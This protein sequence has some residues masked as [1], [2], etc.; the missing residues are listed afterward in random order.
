M[1]QADQCDKLCPGSEEVRFSLHHFD[2]RIGGYRVGKYVGLNDAE[3]WSKEFWVR[4][5]DAPK[6]LKPL[7]LALD[8]PDY[9]EEAKV[10]K[11]FGIGFGAKLASI[12]A[13]G[14]IKVYEQSYRT[15]TTAEDLDKILE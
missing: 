3:K 13:A 8:K 2:L 9:T 10:R 5:R 15:P 14:F 12:A 1:N 4:E 7:P 6:K 11:G